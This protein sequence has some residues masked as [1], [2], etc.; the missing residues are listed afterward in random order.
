MPPRSA[1]AKPKKSQA[2]KKTSSRGSTKAT[3]RSTKRSTKATPRAARSL[4]AVRAGRDRGKAKATP[5]SARGSTKATQRSARGSTKA[6]PRSARGSTKATQRSTPGRT[7]ASPR[8]TKGATKATPRSA[9]GRTKASPRATKGATKATPRSAPSATT[10]TPR[11]GR[12]STPVRPRASAAVAAD[13]AAPAP[14]ESNGDESATWV[15]LPQASDASGVSVSAIRKWYRA[16]RIESRLEVGGVGGR[17]RLVPLEAVMAHAQRSGGPQAG[18]MAAPALDVEAEADEAVDGV[19][20]T[21]RGF[22]VPRDAWD[23]MV[24]Q[25]GNLHQAGQDLAEAGERAAKAET[26]ASF[27]R[28]RLV[29]MRAE[30]DSLRTG[31]PAP[32]PPAVPSQ[33]ERRRRWFRRGP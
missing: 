29:E 32:A 20:P 19:A 26:E 17:Q 5:R 23:S 8:A 3:P 2:A 1:G 15:T 27:L 9:P 22:L 12:G 24:T 16:G 18:Q 31:R 30:N 13:V 4:T 14:I 28:D 21:G 11:S 6:T 10:A 33:E 7:K 25:L